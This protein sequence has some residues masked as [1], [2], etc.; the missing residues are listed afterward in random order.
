[1]A[2]VRR[3]RG[4]LLRVA[5]R[6]GPAIVVGAALAGPAAWVEFSGARVEWWIQGAALIAGA[7]GIALLWTGLVGVKPDW[8]DEP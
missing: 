3:T 5:R 6:R 1:M 2:L 4:A 8:I 7:V